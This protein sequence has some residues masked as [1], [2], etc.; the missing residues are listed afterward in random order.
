VTA[1]RVV[2]LGLLM[3]VGLIY[4]RG[5][6][7]FYDSVGFLDSGRNWDIGMSLGVWFVAMLW[8]LAPVLV[9]RV[10]NDSWQTWPVGEP[11]SAGATFHRAVSRRASW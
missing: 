10:L 5:V 1:V 7:A 9:D 2:E 3:A 8:P 4:L 11:P 6:W